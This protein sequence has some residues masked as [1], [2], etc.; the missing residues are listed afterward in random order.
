MARFKEIL[1]MRLIL[2]LG[3]GLICCTPV[4]LGQPYP[5]IITVAVS[6]P[7]T[8]YIDDYLSQP[9]KI[10]ASLVNTSG[11]ALEV[12]IQGKIQGDGGLLVYTDPGFK[13]S[14]PITLMPG[15]PYYLNRYNLEQVFDADHLK[16]QGISKNEALYGMGLPEDNY[17]ICMQAFDVATGE[18]LSA[19]SPQGCSNSFLVMDLEAPVILSPVDGTEILP[20]TA[21]HISFSWTWPPGAPPGIQFLL[22][23]VEV[24]PSDRNINDAFQSAVK[25]VFFEVTVNFAE[26]MLGPADPSLTEGK[27]Y[28]CRVTAFDPSGKLVFRNQ[29]RSEVISFIYKNPEDE[30][31]K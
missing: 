28:A 7:Y 6:P 9:D 18:A 11:Q 24:Q 17:T 26:Y 21:Q 15:M 30:M 19:E 8:A 23:I 3:L 31:E 10:M 20:V 25:P 22:S 16:Y 27:A 2:V 14:P 4:M 5:V 13:M 1:N 29:G 12:Y